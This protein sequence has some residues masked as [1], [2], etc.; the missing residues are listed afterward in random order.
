MPTNQ[1]HPDLEKQDRPTERTVTAPPVPGIPKPPDTLNPEW[2][3]PSPDSNDR[4]EPP[5]R[6]G[7]GD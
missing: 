1:P 4:D 3:L 2:P 7:G 6:G 5:T